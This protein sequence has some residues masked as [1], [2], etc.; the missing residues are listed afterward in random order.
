MSGRAHVQLDVRRAFW[1]L[2]AAG[3][4]TEAA[5]VAVG[6]ACTTG[7]KWFVEAGGM[8]PIDLVQPRGRY[9][10]FREREEIALDRAAGLGIREIARRLGRSP[11][12]ISREVARGCLTRRPR[13]RY[14]ASVPQAGAE[15]RARRPKPAKL[16]GHPRLGEWVADKLEHLQWSP[17]QIGRRLRLEFPDDESMRISHEAIYQSLYVQGRGALRRELT[18]C[19]RTGRALRTPARRVDGRRERIKDKVMASERPAE[20]EDRAV[21]GHWEGDLIVGKDSGSAIGTLVERST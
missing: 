13:G 12:T 1:R 19:L 4:S 3:S 20:A 14:K 2:I 18:A 16:V 6:V 5:A 21:P 11:S 7:L 9:L 8:P 15:A 10:S 17:E